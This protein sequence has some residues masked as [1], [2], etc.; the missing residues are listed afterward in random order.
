MEK[1]VP[2]H[3]K[4]IFQFISPNHN[5]TDIRHIQ[6]KVFDLNDGKTQIIGTLFNDLKKPFLLKYRACFN[7]FLKKYYHFM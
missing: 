3:S 4:H 1:R 5:Q 6:P 2:V 7:Q